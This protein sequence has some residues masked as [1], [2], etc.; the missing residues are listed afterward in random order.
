MTG[1]RPPGQ[2]GSRD[3]GP[4]SG[5]LAQPADHLPWCMRASELLGRALVRCS[6]RVTIEGLEN[7]PRAGGALIIA[8]NHVSHADPACVAVFITPALGRPVHFM[9]KAEA[10]GWPIAGRFMKANGAFAVRRGAADAEAFRLARRILDEGRVLGVFPEGTRSPTGGLQVARDGVA[11]LALRTGAPILPVG[12]AD[13]D[14]FWPRG[15][16]L[17]RLGGRISLRIGE[18]FTVERGLGPDGRRESLEA[19]TTRLMVRIAALLPER[20][21][22]VYGP[23]LAGEVALPAASGPPPR[24]RASAGGPASAKTSRPNS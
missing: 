23:V 12:L 13:T 7:V 8:G 21:R 22:G 1:A 16:L 9:T 15:R 6:T 19:V 17:W 3:V 20:Q 18:P 24:V 4:G 2:P 5:V 11:L 14:R 10:L